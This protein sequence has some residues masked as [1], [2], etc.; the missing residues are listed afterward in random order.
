MYIKIE[1]PQ[2]MK[3]VMCDYIE[4]QDSASLS[5]VKEKIF[6]SFWTLFKEKLYLPPSGIHGSPND[7]LLKDGN[8]E[9]LSDELLKERL[10]S[11]SYFQAIFTLHGKK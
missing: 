8:V 7:I 2:V 10:A 3:M 5:E 1:Y 4:V 6:K 11:S 9:I